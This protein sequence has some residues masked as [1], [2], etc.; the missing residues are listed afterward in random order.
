MGRPDLYVISSATMDKITLKL[1]AI[2]SGM[3]NVF[4]NG[5]IEFNR[6]RKTLC[7]RGVLA[8]IFLAKEGLKQGKLQWI[9]LH[10]LVAYS[11]CAKNVKPS[12][13]T[14]LLYHM[15]VFDDKS[16]FSVYHK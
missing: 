10:R 14:C 5:I 12:R 1:C 15:S 3:R 7:G 6:I 9:G 11:R 2:H 4:R 8:R 16:P 13:F